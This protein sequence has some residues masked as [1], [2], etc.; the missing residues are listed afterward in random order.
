MS[1]STF[2]AAIVARQMKFSSGA[3]GPGPR[4]E[5]LRKHIEKELDEIRE[6]PTDVTEWIDV[7]ILGMDGAWRCLASQFPWMTEDEVGKMVADA[8]Q[9]KIGVNEERAWP[10]WRKVGQD[11]PIEHK[12]GDDVSRETPGPAPEVCPTCG[13][14]GRHHVYHVGAVAQTTCPRCGGTGYDTR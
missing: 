5:G 14:T 4:T 3:F 1:S 6:D 12:K 7:T 11:A 9:Y 13:G 2:L 10:D 8:L